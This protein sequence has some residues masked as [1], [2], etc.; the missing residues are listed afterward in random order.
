[1]YFFCIPST[2]FECKL[3]K[4]NIY[5]TEIINIPIVIITQVMYMLHK[6][7]HPTRLALC[8]QICFITFF[9]F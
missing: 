1:M 2:H 9:S 3:M 7:Q 6:R 8:K 5:S 4:Y